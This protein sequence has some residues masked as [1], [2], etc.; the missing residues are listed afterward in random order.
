MENK[1]I[2]CRKLE[3]FQWIYTTSPLLLHLH[4]GRRWPRRMYF[5][6]G[7]KSF[8]IFGGFR[9]IHRV[10]VWIHTY[11]SGET[12][13]WK[14]F[15]AS[16]LR[17]WPHSSQGC[18]LGPKFWVEKFYCLMKIRCCFMSF[19]DLL[20]IILSFM[21]KTGKFLAVCYVMAKMSQNGLFLA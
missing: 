12:A 14:I 2:S 6:P 7:A 13:I 19:S 4:G 11:G 16:L 17:S 3:D 1:I 15:T 9:R 10:W 18:P 20:S 5:T 8:K 21:T